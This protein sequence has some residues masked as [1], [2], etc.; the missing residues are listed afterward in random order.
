MSVKALDHLGAVVAQI[1]S[2]ASGPFASLLYG[3]ST[4]GR[5]IASVEA[6]FGAEATQR[7]SAKA[8][9]GRKRIAPAINADKAAMIMR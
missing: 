6:A 2:A 9:C 4:S 8:T 5:A 7:E 3:S 1:A